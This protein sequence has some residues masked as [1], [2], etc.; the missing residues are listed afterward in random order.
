MGNPTWVIGQA[1]EAAVMKQ[2]HPHRA[3]FDGRAGGLEKSFLR[4][5]IILI[6][7]DAKSCN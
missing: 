6:S 7:N 3:G 4:W 2:N 5:N 1:F